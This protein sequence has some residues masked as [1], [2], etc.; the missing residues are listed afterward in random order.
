MLVVVTVLSGLHPFLY[1]NS[2]V[3][4]AAF[5]LYV[6]IWWLERTGN[7]LTTFGLHSHQRRRSLISAALT[8]ATIFPL[9]A[10]GYHLFQVDYRERTPRFDHG[11]LHRWP[12]EIEGRP[13][14]FDGT[15]P[16]VLWEEQDQITLIWTAPP[17]GETVMTR[18]TA[19]A[20]FV[21]VLAAEINQ[22]ELF[23]RSLGSNRLAPRWIA[24]NVVDIKTPKRGGVRLGV[25]Q[26]STLK[27]ELWRNERPVPPDEVGLGARSAKPSTTEP[28]SIDRNYWWLLTLVLTHLLL[29]SLPEEV[30]FRG[31]LQTR[32]DQLFTRRIRFLG[33]PIGLGLVTTS[34][35]FALSHYVV[36]LDPN[37]LVVFFPSLLFG[38]LRNLTSG[39]MAP[40]VVH[41]MSNV[42]LL[43]LSRGYN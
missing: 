38:W 32:L 7:D 18:I 34:A 9:F 42:L 4:A 26:N 29:V 3:L 6:P 5:F 41:G 11:V 8:C 39:V 25:E 33:A 19:D 14:T 23:V 12:Q 36:E 43:L 10:L 30:F 40:I 21:R 28:L 35:L 37:R 1:E 20:P 24:P 16:F 27:V 13:D 17:S 2:Q 22:G 15:R 31:Y